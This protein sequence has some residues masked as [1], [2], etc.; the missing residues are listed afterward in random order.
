MITVAE[1]RAYVEKLAPR[2]IAG[3]CCVA[4]S[5]LV[6]EALQAKYRQPYEVHYATEYRD[7]S[8]RGRVVFAAW[9]KDWSGQQFELPVEVGQLARDFDDLGFFDSVRREACL[10]WMDGRGK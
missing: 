8:V 4:G 7:E 1:V 9:A 2:V 5:C 3:T 10:T 6:A